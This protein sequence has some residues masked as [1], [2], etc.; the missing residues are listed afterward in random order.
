MTWLLISE[1]PDNQALIDSNDII[2]YIRQHKMTNTSILNLDQ[3]LS[4][5]YMITSVAN[6][7]KVDEECKR[8]VHNCFQTI[9]NHLK[10]NV[11]SYDILKQRRQIPNFYM[12]ISGTLKFSE[13][14]F[15]WMPPPPY[16]RLVTQHTETVRI[17]IL[18][19]MLGLVC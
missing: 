14:S 15:Y 16:F 10:F 18:K 13:G 2:Y 3:H 6:L 11:M 1:E 9:N 12:N 19:F 17:N 4:A 8:N 7:P 5:I